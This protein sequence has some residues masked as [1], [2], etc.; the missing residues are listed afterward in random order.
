MLYNGWA[1]GRS[2]C[3]VLRQHCLLGWNAWGE[4]NGTFLDFAV[5]SVQR[6]GTLGITAIMERNNV[7]FSACGHGWP[8]VASPVCPRRG[9]RVGGGVFAFARDADCF[10]WPGWDEKNH[11]GREGLVFVLMAR[12]SK[13]DLRAVSCRIGYRLD[14][15]ARQRCWTLYFRN[16]PEFPPLEREHPSQ[17]VGRSEMWI[18]ALFG[19][20]PLEIFEMH[21]HVPYPLR[22]AD[23]IDFEIQTWCR[24]L[25][26]VRCT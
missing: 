10:C 17:W 15:H 11:A 5:C 12:A 24:D 8:M 1:R 3:D 16:L 6:K 7:L 4:F 23:K 18:D 9:S 25:I 26:V 14:R 22:L 21:S 19:R 20:C 13:R 2:V